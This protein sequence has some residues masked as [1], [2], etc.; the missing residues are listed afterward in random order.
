LESSEPPEEPP[1]P[2]IPNC[3]ALAGVGIGGS[4]VR[5]AFVVPLVVVGAFAA[6]AAWA[7]DRE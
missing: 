3:E 5:E 4:R 2:P 6:V 1:E 7:L